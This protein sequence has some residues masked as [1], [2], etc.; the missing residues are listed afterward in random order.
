MLQIY[1][2]LL[3]Q[4]IIYRGTVYTVGTVGAAYLHTVQQ[5]D[6]AGYTD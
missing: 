2:Q 6:A 1:I 4:L 5:D 3:S